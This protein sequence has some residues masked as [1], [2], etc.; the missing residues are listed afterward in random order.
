MH[1]TRIIQTECKH[2]KKRIC[3]E[4]NCWSKLNFSLYL[5]KLCRLRGTLCGLNLWAEFLTGALDFCVRQ[6]L[7]LLYFAGF[8]LSSVP[9]L[10]V[11]SYSFIFQMLC[12]AEF[13][14]FHTLSL[15]ISLSFVLS[16][17]FRPSH[18]IKW[19]LNWRTFCAIWQALSGYK[20]AVRQAESRRKSQRKSSG[21]QC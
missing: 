1:N 21:K 9:L 18:Q 15:T 3:I 17:W 4:N 14:F 16:L 8:W 19:Q 12:S 2:I 13:G 11:Y 10:F 20:Q 5:D 7:S 6:H